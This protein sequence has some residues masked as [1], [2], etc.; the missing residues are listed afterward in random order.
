MRNRVD[1]EPTSGAGS[2]GAG[3]SGFG[4]RLRR[5]GSWLLMLGVLGV[6]AAPA[7]AAGPAPAWSISSVSHPTTFLAGESGFGLN[8][9][10]YV[11]VVQ[12]VGGES[13]SGPVTIADTL[14]ADAAATGVKVFNSATGEEAGVVCPTIPPPLKTLQCETELGLPPGEPLYIYINTEITLGTQGELENKA[15]VSGGGAAAASTSSLTPVG[16]STAAFAPL[17]FSFAA[18][19]ASGAV[20]EQAGDHP[21]SLTTSFNIATAK[22]ANT[23]FGSYTP[24]EN[25]KDV[26]I[27]LPLGFVGDPQAAP[28]CPVYDLAP[29]ES[30]SN[31]PSASQVGL[32]G[33]ESS[34]GA[35]RVLPIYNVLS[36]PGYPAE[37]GFNYLGRSVIMYASVVPSP[38]GYRLRV[39]VPRLTNF[40]HLTGAYVTFFGDPA[41]H[42]GGSTPPVAFVTNPEDCSAGP[43]S[44]RIEVDSWE[45]PARTSAGEDP[46]NWRSAEAVA[47]PAIGGC[48]LLD[49]QPTIQM[50]PETSQADEPTGYTFDLEVPQPQ[51]VAPVLA[52]PDVKDVVVA[53]PAGVS[54]SP[55]A[56]NGLSACSPEAIGLLATEE[57][58]DGFQRAAPGHCP[59]SSQVGTV[60]ITTPLL[61][62]PLQG[63]VYVAQPKCGNAGQ[64]PCSEADAAAGNIFGLY[65][66]AEGAGV[67]VKLPGS[68][69]AD[70]H[71]GQLTARFADN[72]QL[73]FSDLRLQLEGGP[74]APLANPQTCGTF[75]TTSAISA[76]SS[77]LTPEATPSSQFAVDWDGAG[78]ACP[79]MPFAPS[80]EAGTVSSAAGAFSAFSLRFGRHDREQSLSS[81]SVQMPSG[82]LGVVKGVPL[83]GEPQAAQGTCAPE[84]RIGTVTA[85]A[86]TGSHPFYFTGGVYLTGPYNGA[87]FGLSI[88]VPAVA[89]PFN[90]GD[91]VVRAAVSI[92]PNDAHL[93]VVANPVPQIVAGVPTRL[94]SIDVVVDRPKFTFNPTNC[95]QQQVTGTI[96]SAQGAQASVA[97]PFA[98]SGCGQLPFKPTF[99]V[100][101]QARTSKAN[102]ASL[103]VEVAQRPGEAS[104]QKVDVQL[105]KALPARLATLHGACPEAQFAV[106]PAGCPSASAV[107]TATAI[108]PILGVPLTGP[109]YLVS[110]GGAA[111]PDLVVVLQGDERGGV[112]RIDLRGR[113]D[114]KHGVTYSNFD[115]VPDAPISSFDLSLPEGPRSVLAANLSMRAKGSF[116]GQ[117]LVMPTTITGQNGVRVRQST[118][119][120]VTGCVKHKVKRKKRS[121]RSKKRAGRVGR[122]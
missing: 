10:Q 49:F 43:L 88:V 34:G 85:A 79:G 102:G 57:G 67:I 106:N 78:G 20:D 21:N 87:P 15:T 105:P 90:F 32:L 56:A 113:T 36:E 108:T 33:F 2:S 86:G 70:P 17:N 25:V 16:T 23:S 92:D 98:A 31:C 74:Q 1:A 63:R 5:A 53:L 3:S 114:I 97:S 12:N 69:A 39:V 54:V 111:F 65:I 40:S 64:A 26:A 35:G 42:D 29:N 68:V 22:S 55:G 121:N 99:T 59:P 118:K 48:E 72:P 94:Q 82:L 122:H 116:C 6:L 18:R 110:H 101:T 83:C 24:V 112:I 84:S 77:P 91:I 60:T 30:G 120:A 75:T 119:I 62:Q 4:C 115:T 13:S 107:G 41:L 58:P 109:A 71:T 89:G 104:V 80:F 73:P 27:E 47:Y 52:A 117:S 66:E 95:V 51:N 96:V 100:S 76:W 38:A 81:L 8:P 14:P 37:F 7:G 19:T 61:A 93:I 44:A 46:A 9:N 28:H 11:L 45:N 50:R 103:H